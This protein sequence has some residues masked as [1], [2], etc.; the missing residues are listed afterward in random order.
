MVVLTPLIY[1]NKI[2]KIYSDYINEAYDML[3][4]GYVACHEEVFTFPV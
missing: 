2:L 1:Q 4:L 3:R